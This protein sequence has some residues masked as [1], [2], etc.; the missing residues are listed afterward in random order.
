MAALD[1]VINATAED[2]ASAMAW[3]AVL[4]LLMALVLPL[5]RPV[6]R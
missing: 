4:G 1:P 3:T 6:Y 2:L 5:L